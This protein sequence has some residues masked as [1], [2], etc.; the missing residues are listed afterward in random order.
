[1]TFPLFWLRLTGGLGAARA[2]AALRQGFG[3]L[4][5]LQARGLQGWT[6]DSSYCDDWAGVTCNASGYVTAL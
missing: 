4:G 1:M 5:Q 2:M 6:P 3:N